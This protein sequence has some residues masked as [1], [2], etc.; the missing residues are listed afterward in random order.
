MGSNH[1][2]KFCI[3]SSYKIAVR[4]RHQLHVYK[5]SPDAPWPKRSGSNRHFP[6]ILEYVL[7]TRTTLGYLPVFP[8]C[9][10]SFPP[11][12]R[13]G[14]E[15][16]PHCAAWRRGW[17]LNPYTL[18]DYSWFSKPVPY[19]FRLTPPYLSRDALSQSKSL[20]IVKLLLASHN[21]VHGRTNNYLFSSEL[22]SKSFAK[23][24]MIAVLFF[25]CW[26]IDARV[27]ASSLE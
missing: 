13:G 5:L 10:R 17:D 4:V 19:Q 12:E 2:Q 21:S 22:V 3:L 20:I 7:T 26:N 14:D 25:R 11:S 15:S 9:Q 18:S 16:S 24:A 6:F 23:F 8:G 1:K 27:A